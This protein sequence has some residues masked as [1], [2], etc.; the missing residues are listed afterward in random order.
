MAVNSFLF[1]HNQ[2]NLCNQF[3]TGPSGL[4]HCGCTGV[5]GVNGPGETGGGS[6]HH[7]DGS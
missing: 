5:S 7:G 6:L 1:R 3:F 4:P 2:G